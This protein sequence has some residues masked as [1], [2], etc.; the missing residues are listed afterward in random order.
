[1]RARHVVTLGICIGAAGAMAVFAGCGESTF[2]TCQDNNVCG[3]DGSVDGTSTADQVSGD[4][5]VGSDGAHDGGVTEGGG[6]GGIAC[7]AAT[8]IACNGACVDKE[9][10]P[11]NCGSCGH[12]CTGPEAGMGTGVC[13]SGACQVAC[14]AEA[15]TTLYCASTGKCVDPTTTSNCGICGK[16]CYGP[17]AGPGHAVCQPDGACAVACDS[18]AGDG[19]PAELL[20]SGA[21]VSSAT[22]TNCNTCGTVCPAPTANGTAACAG[23][24]L[25]CGFACTAGFH[26]AGGGA[27]CN[28]TCSPNSGD[29]ATDACVVADGL[30]IFVSPMG[31]DS[32][33]G[34][35]SKEHPYGTI[36]HAMAQATTTGTPAVKRVYACG[37]FTAPLV[38]TGA[39]DG[40]IVYGGFDCTTWAYSAATPTTVA[41]TAAGYA[42]QVSGLTTGVKFEDFA[43]TAVSASS[44][45]SA[46]PASSIAVFVSGSPLTL[47]RVAVTAGSGQPGMP[48]GTGS[49]WS[50]SAPA[51]GGAS[52]TGGGAGGGP[53]SCT[54]GDSSHGG[55]GGFYNGAAAQPGLAN[56]NAVTQNGGS[57]E[58]TSCGPPTGGG[59]TNGAPGSPA[60]AV[61]GITSSG[62]LGTSG[63]VAGGVGASGQAGG[64]GQG[65]G[66]GGANDSPVFGVGGPG[67]GGG[68]GGCGGGAGTGGASGGSSIGVASHDSALVLTGSIAA[69]TGGAGGAGG[70]G[71]A[72]EGGAGGGAGAC[73]GGTGG[74]GGTGSGGGGGAGGVSSGIV[75]S[76]TAPSFNGAAISSQVSVAGITLGTQGSG[77]GGTGAIPGGAG[78]TPTAMAVLQSP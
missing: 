17:E 37:T 19:G 60:A 67:G 9:T 6:E 44:T 7:D 41:P 47:T 57:T 49:N 65:G 75:W 21:C 68:A 25:A 33:P 74:A 24:P 23:S 69:G 20:C 28:V 54:N 13:A 8:A 77:G 2:G 61:S 27:A 14:E 32:A 22:I 43:F 30:G 38:V 18:D 39:D 51:G 64:V 42:L 53:N 76:G 71:Q 55:V 50:G 1:M 62:S 78:A 63:W 12:A 35:G 31:S 59:T 15:G 26:P 45:P 66:G 34:D 73:S 3:G 40:V 52:V 58:A 72:G 11:A 36:A 10:D 16:T 46:T 70:A 48:G 5:H 56:G 4:Q 29:P